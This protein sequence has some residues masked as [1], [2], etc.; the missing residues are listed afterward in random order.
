MKTD[1]L[2]K[3][4][5]DSSYKSFSKRLSRC[6]NLFPIHLMTFLSTIRPRPRTHLPACNGTVE[7]RAFKHSF[8]TSNYVTLPE[9][10]AP[11]SRGQLPMCAGRKCDML[12]VRLGLKELGHIKNKIKSAA[13]TRPRPRQCY[14]GRV[15][16][17]VPFYIRH[18]FH[19][20]ARRLLVLAE[21]STVLDDLRVRVAKYS[22]SLFE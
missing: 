7:Y 4:D 20:S 6:D 8:Q 17:A 2:Q 11:D 19:S 9:I 3:R 10:W 5:S 18:H 14:D 16:H 1:F 13:W 12:E 22:L 21:C 15:P